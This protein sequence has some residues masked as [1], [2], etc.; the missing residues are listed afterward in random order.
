MDGRWIA[1]SGSCRTLGA[2]CHSLPLATL[3]SRAARA[4]LA[5]RQS[6][7]C[8]PSSPPQDRSHLGAHLHFSPATLAI[9][10]RQ[11][12]LLCVDIFPCTSDPLQ[13]LANVKILRW[14]GTVCSPLELKCLPLFP[15]PAEAIA[16]PVFAVLL[17]PE[18]QIT[19]FRALVPAHRLRAAIL[20]H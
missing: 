11:Q 19:A 7:A 18:R 20:E 5:L 9:G 6:R 3:I 16:S 10:L 14:K 4:I 15:T 12:L 2:G 17:R 1:T 8:A 13:T